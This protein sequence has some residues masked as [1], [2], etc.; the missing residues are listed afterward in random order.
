MTK[1]PEI[2]DLVIAAGPAQLVLADIESVPY[3]AD[4][5]CAEYPDPNLWFA[6]TSVDAA[7]AKAICRRCPAL[8]ACALYALA[9]PDEYGIWGATD[10]ADRDRLNK[11]NPLVIS[12]EAYEEGVAILTSN[13]SVLASQRKVHVRTIVR[14]K[15]LLRSQ[16]LF[17]GEVGLAA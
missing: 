4:A 14:W 13:A 12:Q 1:R 5:L 17:A 11:K 2:I 3:F 8:E 16:S 7:L 9:Q 6:E 10:K 15:L